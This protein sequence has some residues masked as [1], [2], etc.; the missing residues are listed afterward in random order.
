[1][2]SSIAQWTLD[3]RS[4]EV[5]EKNRNHPDLLVTG[6]D[7][8]AEAE[9]LIALGAR[10]ADVGQ[11]PDDPFVVLADPEDNEFCLL[12]RSP[13]GGTPQGWDA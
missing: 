1:M 4:L 2:T 13:N 10:R 12:R 6:G 3:A 8:D 11:R 7:V 5:R 9:R